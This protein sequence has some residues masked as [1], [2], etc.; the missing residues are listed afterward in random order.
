[1][2]KNRKKTIGKD[3]LKPI[4]VKKVAEKHRVK[5]NLVYKVLNGT[6]NNE[7]VLED[8][9]EG[10]NKLLEAVRNLIPF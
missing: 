2:S 3:E 5:P 10:H 4:V 1:M 8:Y 6:R 7:G 9:M